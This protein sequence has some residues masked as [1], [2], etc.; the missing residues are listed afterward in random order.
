ME[1]FGGWIFSLES[2]PS[3]WSL[4]TLLYYAH[5]SYSS[6]LRRLNSSA[7]WLP[8]CHSVFQGS[9]IFLRHFGPKPENSQLKYNVKKD[10]FQQVGMF[11]S[12][13]SHPSFFQVS[14]IH[15]KMSIRTYLEINKIPLSITYKTLHYIHNKTFTDCSKFLPLHC[16]YLS[17]YIARPSKRI[18]ISDIISYISG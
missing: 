18:L 10:W 4:C 2:P 17:T 12:E 5:P 8:P 16:A 6:S 14:W 7:N 15:R 13:M 11:F 9:L 3:P 1:N